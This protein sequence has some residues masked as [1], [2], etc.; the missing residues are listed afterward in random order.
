MTD[1]IDYTSA[2]AA[3][4]AERFVRCRLVCLRAHPSFK[5][6]NPANAVISFKSVRG[7]DVELTAEFGEA[8]LRG[9]DRP[10]G[11]LPHSS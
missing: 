8:T 6:A 3:A 5:L 2:P 7:D 1:G 4:F 11:E 9:D 10:N